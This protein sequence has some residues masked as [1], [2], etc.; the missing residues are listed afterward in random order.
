MEDTVFKRSP[1]AQ[2]AK[3]RELA[4]KFR[5]RSIFI[6]KKFVIGRD[7]GCDI[8]LQGD[9][10]VSRRHAMIEFSQGEYCI[11]DLGST[12]GTY[13]NNKPLQKGE[14]RPI[15]EGDIIL[16][17]KTSMPVGVYQP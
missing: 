8:R 7:E 3:P 6:P 12:N 15:E 14:R 1:E 11:R 10:L 2:K 13:V 4:L 5:D 16:I 17:G 9:S